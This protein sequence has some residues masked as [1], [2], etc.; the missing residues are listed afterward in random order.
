MKSE[1]EVFGTMPDG[2][3]IRAYTIT[4][5]NGYRMRCMDYGAT[6]IGFR[7]PDREGVDQQ[8]TLCYDDLDHYLAG[9]PFFGSTVGRVANR[10]SGARFELDGT[11]YELPANER[12]NLLHSG[13]EGFHARVWESQSFERADQAGVMFRIESPDGDQ[14]FPG[15]LAVTVSYTLT[16]SNE[17]HIEYHAES[18]AATPVNLTNH[19][20]W[21]LAGAPDRRRLRGEPVPA[22]EPRGGA[23]GEHE[24][25]LYAKQYL[26]VDE[27]LLPTGRLI[28]VDGGPFDFS[29]PKPIG[30]DLAAASGGY[31]HCYVLDPALGEGMTT[32]HGFP[33]DLHRAAVVRDPSSGRTMEVLTT[34]PAIQFYTGNM[35]PGVRDQFGNEFQKHDAICVET[36]FHPDAVNHAE[37]PSIILRPGETFQHR[38]VHRFRVE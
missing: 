36:Q 5:E 14:G 4:N 13:A 20:Y 29:G 23:V 10:I 25:T 18:D 6:L 27:E 15:E 32:Q 28:E 30:R 9:H 22:P 26:E 11:T 8:V 12:G 1:H 3:E 24:V 17:L 16:E 38:T 2:R 35:L 21:N 7:A 37:F 19:T 31:D 34:S 33:D